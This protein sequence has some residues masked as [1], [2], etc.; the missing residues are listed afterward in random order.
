M[1]ESVMERTI[2]VRLPE[3]ILRE[4]DAELEYREPVPPSRSHLMRELLVRGLRD[5]QRERDG[6]RK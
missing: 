1:A 4:I 3:R 5:V 2:P 6:K